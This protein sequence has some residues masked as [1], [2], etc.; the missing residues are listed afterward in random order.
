MK[1][2]LAILLAFMMILSTM[3]SLNLVSAEPS[4]DAPIYNF[5]AGKGNGFSA[6]N[7]AAGVVLYSGEW[8]DFKSGLFPLAAV[9]DN[10]TA[11]LGGTFVITYDKSKVTLMAY[12]DI[13]EV[14]SEATSDSEIWYSSAH[15]SVTGA[16]GV[17]SGFG[18]EDNRGYAYTAWAAMKG[19]FDTDAIK[20]KSRDAEL[21][22][23]VFKTNDGVTVDD[24]DENTFKLYEGQT[25]ADIT[26]GLASGGSP[27]S[28]NVKIDGS[29]R[30]F[31]VT[32]SLQEREPMTVNFVYPNSTPK[33]AEKF[34]VTFVADGV[35]VD[36]ITK[37][38]GETVA[39]S[40]FPE[41]PAKA[42]FTG[43]WD[44]KEDITT[45]TTVNAV[46]TPIPVEKFTV[47]FVADGVTVD[48]IT[49]NVGE[50]VAVSEFP[51][52][53]E[54]AGYTGAW[55]TTEAVTATKT[56][57]AV[58]TP[59]SVVPSADAPIYNF[60]AGKGNGFSAGNKAAGVVLYSG[61]WADFKSGLFPL[62]A[63]ADNTTAALGGTFVITYDKSKVTLMAYDD[64]DEVWSEATS[65]SEIWYSSAHSS[66]T[67]ASGVKSGFGTEDNR[68]YAYTA[69]AAMKGEFDTDAIKGKSRDAELGCYVFKTNDGVTVDD[70][71]ENTFKLYEGQTSAD[72][73][74]GLASG[75]S[76]LSFNV[77]IDGSERKFGVT[78]SLQE[79]EPMTVNFVYPN[80]TPKPAEKFTVTFVAD[81]V[82]VDTITK[83]VGETVAVSE[84]PEVPAKAGFTGAWDVKEDITTTTTVNAVYTPISTGDAKLNAIFTDGFKVADFD[85]DTKEYKDIKASIGYDNYVIAGYADAGVKIEYSI[86]NGAFESANKENAFYFDLERGKMTSVKIKLTNA[87]GEETIYSFE[88]VL[89]AAEVSYFETSGFEIE[90]FT[91]ETKEYTVTPDSSEKYMRLWGKGPVDDDGIKFEYAI[92]EATDTPES[93]DYEALA[94][95]C[96]ARENE[97]FEGTPNFDVNWSEKG[98]V[99]LWTEDGLSGKAMFIKVISEGA[100]DS[101]YVIKFQ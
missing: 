21:G 76:P 63:V 2:K 70:F 25:S 17:K 59:A 69:W 61:E 78:D 45:T 62:A 32:D 71:D 74:A 53:P 28:F 88:I 100:P 96:D 38:V 15:S 6:G 5:V 48:T 60:V 58:Y 77:K 67:G 85:A 98:F 44:V 31:G 27:L 97:Y 14:W 46:Y 20:G 80:S 51:A 11:A 75:G 1:K 9:A 56:V 87:A 92:G 7:K 99:N 3:C 79:R 64:I 49:K 68:G 30:K 84:F 41:V 55:D 65:D 8:A 57:T 12:D 91:P 54:K 22:C 50:T 47:T 81:G 36:T 83:N 82:T 52:V 42:G 18:T 33:P 4:A 94:V 66:V 23:Y 35:T 29:E 13:D 95:N 10:T 93:K 16:S 19:E 43:A 34:T 73:T 72:I 39:V 89:P 40:E 90:G 24:F 37:N 86:D 26:A 101:Y